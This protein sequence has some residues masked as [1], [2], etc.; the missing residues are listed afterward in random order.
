MPGPLLAPLLVEALGVG[1][2]RKQLLTAAHASEG[3]AAARARG[4]WR[5]SPK[6]TWWVLGRTKQTAPW[7][8]GPEGKG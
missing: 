4:E 6:N 5:T 1:T 3:K 2:E 8:L 7:Q